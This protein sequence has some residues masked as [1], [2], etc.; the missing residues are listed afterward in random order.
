MS[1]AADQNSQ[2][3]LNGIFAFKVGMSSIYSETGEYIPVT[4]LK[5]EPWVVTQVKT[6][7]KEG[8][9]AVQVAS[10][11]MKAKNSSQSARKHAQAAGFENGSKHTA[12]IRQVAPEGATVGQKV[13]IDS[14][15]EGDFVKLTGRTKG[16]GFTGSQK[17]WNFAGGPASHGSK[18]H[19]RPGSSGN[20]TWPG[21]VMPGKKFP[22]HYG[23]VVCSIKNV[24]VVK[25]LPEEQVI[26]VKGPVPGARNSLVRLVKV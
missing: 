16:H 9:D 1:E 14:L 18:F 4:V 23:D 3:K 22:G 13:S 12:E 24:Q 7:A 20:R 5:Y 17:R 21:R 10:G 11:P 19:R 2:V 25:V 26:M 8:Y 6:L 15:V